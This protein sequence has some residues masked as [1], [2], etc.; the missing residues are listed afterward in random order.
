MAVDLGKSQGMHDYLTWV[1]LIH[2]TT[3]QSL[4]MRQMPLTVAKATP[5]ASVTIDIP[6]G[7]LAIVQ[8]LLFAST[9]DIDGVDVQF[10]PTA[11]AAAA[12]NGSGSGGGA[13]GGGVTE[14]P[15]DLSCFQ[16][17]GV[18]YEG[19]QMTPPPVH[20]AAGDMGHLLLSIGPSSPSRSPS[21]LLP[22]SASSSEAL[23][24]C[25]T[26]VRTV[27]VTPTGMA[28][29]TIA[30]TINVACSASIDNAT[31]PMVRGEEGV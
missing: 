14:D 18:D 20:I 22:S 27:L 31:T 21:S 15:L 1:S 26:H 11:A 19:N 13:G 3:S 25:G 23:L 2:N 12:E 8:I 28:S 17:S 30:L 24:S 9:T 7:R 29:T 4:R 10:P 5:N 16:T 6:Q